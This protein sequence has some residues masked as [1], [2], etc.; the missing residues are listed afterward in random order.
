M[1]HGVY[2]RNIYRFLKSG[3]GLVLNIRNKKRARQRKAAAVVELAVCL[4]VIALLAIGSM[5]AASMIFLRQA[6]VQSAY[7]TVKEVSKTNGNEALALQRGREVLEFR[8][9]EDE[10]VTFDPPNLDDVEQGTEITV[11][12]SAPG[13]TNSVLPFGPFRDREV[14]VS[15]TMIKE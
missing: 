4:P 12:V 15:A 3:M 10:T 1:I 13:N 14:S 9:V 2:P 6:L 5:E 11:T 7:E 8:N